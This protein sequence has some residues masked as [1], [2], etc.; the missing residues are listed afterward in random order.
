MQ[1]LHRISIGGSPFLGLFE[2]CSLC[3]FN[4]ATT[5]ISATLANSTQKKPKERK[6]SK[7]KPHICYY[8][9]KKYF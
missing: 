8:Q 7:K 1:L 6:Y 9:C 4:K 3:Y 5:V 2:N